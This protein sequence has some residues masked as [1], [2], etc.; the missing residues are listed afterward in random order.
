[1]LRPTSTE[2]PV[3]RA[4]QIPFISHVV[5]AFIVTAA[6]AFVP[7]EPTIAVST[8]CTAVSRS[9][10]STV[11][12]ARYHIIFN[13]EMLSSSKLSFFRMEFLKN[14]IFTSSVPS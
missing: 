7:S 3:P 8:Y 12:H 14:H 10:S 5:D 1:M 2:K 9:C 4:P 13:G 11:G 6:V